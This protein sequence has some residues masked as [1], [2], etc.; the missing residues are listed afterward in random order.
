M[1]TLTFLEVR[2][3]PHMAV[4][5]SRGEF[6]KLGFSGVNVIHVAVMH[7]SL[8]LAWGCAADTV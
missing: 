6:A 7:Q 5:A 1:E 3:V 2:K 8:S 4:F